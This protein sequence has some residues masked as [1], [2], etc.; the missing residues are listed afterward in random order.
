[1]LG[2][3]LADITVADV[4]EAVEENNHHKETPPDA[5][6]EGESGGEVPAMRESQLLWNRL[7]QR[8]HG[9]LATITLED[10]VGGNGILN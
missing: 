5:G 10:V 4:V 7:S 6:A 3:P 1:V 8:V 2:R 9:F